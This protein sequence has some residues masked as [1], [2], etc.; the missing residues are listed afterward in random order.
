MNRN[1]SRSVANYSLG[2][3]GLLKKRATEG[4]DETDKQL[5][6]INQQISNQIGKLSTQSKN[7]RSHR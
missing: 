5:K 6:S 4:K 1:V 2:L 3:K 7:T